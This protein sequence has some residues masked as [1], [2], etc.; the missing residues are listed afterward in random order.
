MMMYSIII[1]VYNRTGEVKEL[2]ESAENLDFDR[3]RFEFL[4]VDDGSKDG[5]QNYIEHYRSKTGIQIRTIYQE[6]K[7][8]GEARNNGMR[9]AS[10]QYFI[11][12]DSDC[13]FPSHWLCTIDR[14]IKQ[15]GYEAFGGPDTCHESFSPLLKAI[16]YSMT[17]K[18]GTGGT[19]GQK[20]SIGKFY[21]RSFNMGIHRKVFEN[22][23]GMNQLRHGQDMDF[24]QRIYDAGYKV[25]LISDAFVYHKRRT[26]LSKFYRQIFNWG[27]ARIN[28]SLAHPSLLKPI[29]L[30]PAVVVLG[31]ILL[32][33][34]TMIFPK[35]GG[36]LW[37][38]TGL[39]YLLVNLTAFFQS[40]IQYRN[41][42]AALLSPVTL[43]I[44]VFAYGLGLI[45]ALWQ[46][47]ILGRKEA[48]GF[49]KNY[50]SK[51]KLESR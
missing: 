20:K 29:H 37:A 25:G 30:I 6:N 16:T 49:V 50:Y 18:L 11:F 42:E 27:V 17:S 3:E 19:R 26:S 46:T 8:P 9:N 34:F 2:L 48:E 15:H 45:K 1:A 38:I 5:F 41:I 23:G 36:Y 33:F 10:G 24:S 32:A 28:L 14:E 13:M 12:V 35:W 31:L 22:I 47:K 4:F 43:N 7:G 44:Q 39:V 51:K 40:F 21:P